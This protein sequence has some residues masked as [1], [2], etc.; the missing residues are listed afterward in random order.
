MRGT[1]RPH[2]S[3]R[4]SP[5]LAGSRRASQALAV[6]AIAAAS[7]G[8]GSDRSGTAE[9]V[10]AT[11]EAPERISLSVK[12]CNAALYPLVGEFDDRIIV[13]I[14]YTDYRPGN[15]CMDVARVELR[16]PIG[17]RKLIDGKTGN[18]VALER[19]QNATDG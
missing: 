17:D 19:A 4:G 10:D 6:A 12:T 15:D 9:I 11:L 3:R 1:L 16:A 5:P 14:D 8:C 2:R 7:A 13:R 18:A